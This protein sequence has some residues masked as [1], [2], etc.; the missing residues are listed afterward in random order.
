ML[1]T[2]CWNHEAYIG[3]IT[4]N[5][6]FT[7]GQMSGEAEERMLTF[8]KTFMDRGGMQMQF[9]CVSKDTLLKAR[10]HP[11]EYGD[12]LV[13]V[14]GFS[15]YFCKLNPQLQQEVIDRNEHAF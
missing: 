15:A 14:G 8:I 7:P 6:K 3:G 13:R 10:E 11:E 1:S 5:M 9:N 4:V 2:T 12:L